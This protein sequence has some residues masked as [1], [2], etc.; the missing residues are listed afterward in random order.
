[1]KGKKKNCVLNNG[2]DR[3]PVWISKERRYVIRPSSTTDEAG[4]EVRGQ[5]I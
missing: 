1:M 3:K 4:I 5:S 2:F